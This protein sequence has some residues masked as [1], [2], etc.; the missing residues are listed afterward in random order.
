MGGNSCSLSSP[1]L[2]SWERRELRLNLEKSKYPVLNP[3]FLLEIDYMN[4]F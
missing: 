4:D 1:T 2:L 3:C